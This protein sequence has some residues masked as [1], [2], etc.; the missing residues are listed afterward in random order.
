MTL[1]QTIP[2]APFP[3]HQEVSVNKA[4][5]LSTYI[6]QIIRCSAAAS[7]LRTA[8]SLDFLLI[9]AVRWG[10]T[11]WGGEPT[12]N[13]RK[14]QQSSLPWWQHQWRVWAACPPPPT[15]GV[16]PPWRP[17]WP[18]HRPPAGDGYDLLWLVLLLVNNQ[19]HIQILFTFC[20]ITS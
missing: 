12:V 5:F 19:T 7:L 13:A 18:G 15:A 20:Q 2:G 8:A 11:A 14:T 1:N 17:R 9:L 6:C 4:C 3:P 16:R 10:D